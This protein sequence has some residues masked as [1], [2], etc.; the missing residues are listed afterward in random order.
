M[1][2]AAE[3]R[4]DDQ[5]AELKSLEAG[6]QNLLAEMEAK[7]DERLEALVK[8][9]ETM[10]PKDAARIFNTLDN[11]VM[12]KVSQR[13]KSANLA[14]VMASMSSERAEELTRMLASR[15]ELPASAEE[16]MQR[17]SAG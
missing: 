9:Y 17:A 16:V 10:K 15:A 1:A 5:I 4:L 3:A 8:V 2:V 14:A 13:M 11:D 7:R 12:M 6:V